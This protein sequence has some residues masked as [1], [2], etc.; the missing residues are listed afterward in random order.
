MTAA[1]VAYLVG[2]ILGGLSDAGHRLYRW[3]LAVC[4][5]MRAMAIRE[6]SFTLGIEE[7]YLLVDKTPAISPRSRRRRCSPN[8]RRLCAARSAPNSCA[9]RSRSAPASAS[10]CRRRATN[11]SGCATPS[12]PSPRV[13]LRADRLLDASLRRMASQQHTD[14]ER[15]NVLAAD[16]QHVARRMVI[17]GMHVHVGIE[18]D[19]LR[20]DLLSQATYFLPHLL[21]LSTSS[22]FWHGRRPGSNPTGSRCST[23]CRAPACRI[24]SRATANISAPSSFWSMPG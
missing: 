6:P 7:E 22:P 12:A 16:L 18:D 15:Y 23:N 13:R 19:E 20:I 11:W 10:R 5:T 2:V 21:A 24:I 4:A 9:R 17:C 8:A 1:A 3:T 14:K